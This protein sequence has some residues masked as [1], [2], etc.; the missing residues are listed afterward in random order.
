MFHMFHLWELSFLPLSINPK[1]L[2]TLKDAWH[3]LDS[4]YDDVG[5]V[6]AKLKAEIASIRL[7]SS[8]SP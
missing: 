3:M 5:E 2:R 8:G 7:K 4:H 6:H 1:N